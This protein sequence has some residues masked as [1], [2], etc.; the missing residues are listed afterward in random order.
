M[1]RLIAWFRALFYRGVH[2]AT[3]GAPA[4]VHQ[5]AQ[6]APPEDPP[7]IVQLPAP[8][9]AKEKTRKVARAKEPW[10][11]SLA[12]LLG[13]IDETF[14]ALRIDWDDLSFVDRH[15]VAGMKKMGPMVFS[16]LC[17]RDEFTVEPN[18]EWPA[19]MLLSVL[20]GGDSKKGDYAPDF[21]F[22]TKTKKVPWHVTRVAGEIFHCGFAWR[23]PECKTLFWY[24]VYVGIDRS[25]GVVS[26]THQMCTKTH[27]L[28]KGRSRGQSYTRTSWEKASWNSGTETEKEAAVR[29][30]V[31]TFFNT[32]A[33]NREKWSVAVNRSGERA[34]FYVEP[35]DTKNFFRNRDHQCTS[36]DGTRKKIIHLVEEHRR[37]LADGQVQTVRE[38]IRGERSFTWNGM[39]CHVT[40][41]KYHAFSRD[42]FVDPSGGY[43]AGEAEEL[44]RAGS[45]IELTK[46]ADMLH[47]LE[48]TKQKRRKLDAVH[49]PK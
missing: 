38:H 45:V 32:W 40:S 20:H 7:T 44:L 1:K 41:P 31:A 13:H 19:F 30:C 9:A 46:A 47:E 49:G 22:A 10:R 27:K 24:G 42:K 14:A 29:N 3:K 6:D 18:V 2:P 37:T 48:E 34:T 12:A 16:E 23:I 8:V 28:T 11:A 36:K 5:P 17:L 35:K 33:S 21:F 43:S 26:L 15:D 4:I 39:S 25:T